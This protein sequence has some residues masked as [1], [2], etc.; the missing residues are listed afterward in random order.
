MG[1]PWAGDAHGAGPGPGDVLSVIKE[2]QLQHGLRHEDYQRYR[3]YC[4]R[5]LRRIRKCVNLVQGVRQRFVQKRLAAD[6][7]TDVRCLYIPLVEAE[8]CWSYA[9]QL[10]REAIEQEDPRKRYHML[11]KL[12]KAEQ[13]ALELSTLCEQVP[14]DA[15]TKLEVQ[16]YHEW[17][18]G[19]LQFELKKDWRLA[20]ELLTK[21]KLIYEKM[22]SAVSGDAVMTYKQKVIDIE[23]SVKYCAYN[24]GDTTD[25]S[26]LLEMRLTMGH[27]DIVLDELIQKTRERQAGSL[28]EVT[29]RGRT[30][31]VKND[32]VRVFLLAERE[33]Q[34]E[35]EAAS[36][37]DTKIA[38]FDRIIKDCV[39]VLQVIKE[40]L[41]ADPTFRQIQRGQEI[42]GHVPVQIF[43]HTYLQYLKIRKTVQKN[44]VMVDMCYYL[45]RMFAVGKQWPEVVALTKRS[46][47][48]IGQVESSVGSSQTVTKEE[49]DEIIKLDEGLLIQA[50]ASSIL[51]SNSQDLAKDMS[52]MSIT[53]DKRP[54]AERLEQYLPEDPSI[55]A[56]N[57][58]L[59]KSP[60]DMQPIPCKPL[61]YDLAGNHVLLPD[62]RHKL[63][64]QE[65]KGGISGYLKTWWGGGKK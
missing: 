62:L 16:A 29:W 14:V 39:D 5:R 7:V 13:Y 58:T 38:V 30:M 23:S 21:A 15:R 4:S 6:Q 36:D 60:P 9:M 64:T 45:A 57:V 24:I 47:E 18:S 42:D 35:V 55:S 44:L 1:I 50:Q 40:E 41:K 56:K 48:Y 63:E 11:N 52:K 49:V 37:F 65:K 26:D 3:S 54:I 59:I 31:P 2:S 27:T 17:M 51:D 22:S 10:K 34:S 25:V 19:T 20:M 8:R 12:R 32:K 28:Y 61:F 53:A 33:I 43:L 46:Q